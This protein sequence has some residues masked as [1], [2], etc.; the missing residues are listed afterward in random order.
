MKTLYLTLIAL[1]VVAISGAAIADHH[2]DGDHVGMPD[3]EKMAAAMAVGQPGPEHELLKKLAGDWDY[4]ITYTMMPGAPEQTST[5]TAEHELELGG[6]FLEQEVEGPMDMGGQTMTYEGKGF[7]GYDNH[8]K[9]YQSFWIDNMNTGM[10]HGSGSFDAASMTL[11]E[12]GK[13]YCPMRGHEIDY[14]SELKVIDDNHFTYT[15][16][17]TGGDA[18]FKMME[19]KYARK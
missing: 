6:R 3:A 10:M 11:T 19:I 12:T 15:T 5:G 14:K 13:H 2:M 18:P 17:E 8:S 16:Y 4:T 1:V 7:L 9:Q